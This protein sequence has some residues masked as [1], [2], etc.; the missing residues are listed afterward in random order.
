MICSLVQSAVF[1]QLSFLFSFHNPQPESE[2]SALAGMLQAEWVFGGLLLAANRVG[3]VLDGVS[4]CFGGVADLCGVEGE[5]V[6]SSC[7]TCFIGRTE[8]SGGRR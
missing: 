2:D 1:H 5:L 6:V 8:G 3:A 7:Y 4:S